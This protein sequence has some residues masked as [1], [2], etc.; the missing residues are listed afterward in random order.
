MK[1][2]NVARDSKRHRVGVVRPNDAAMAQALIAEMERQYPKPSPEQFQARL[3]QSQGYRFAGLL[4]ASPARKESGV[5]VR[6]L[7]AVDGVS[8]IDRLQ[9]ADTCIDY[10]ALVYGLRM[11]G[12]TEPSP[13][14][15]L[16]FG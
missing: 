7:L 13:G 4:S 15:E 11:A 3:L 5:D 2:D 12:E 8:V 6:D 9:G 16:N 14:D 1:R 10:D